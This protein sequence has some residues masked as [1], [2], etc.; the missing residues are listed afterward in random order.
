MFTRSLFK[1]ADMPAQHALLDE[2]ASLVGCGV[3][4]STARQ[5]FGRINAANLLRAHTGCGKAARASARSCSKDFVTP[6][7]VMR[8]HA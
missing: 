7:T 5:H 8:K 4:R 1:T 2:L 3:I 6:S